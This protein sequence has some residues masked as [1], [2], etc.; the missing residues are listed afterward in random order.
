M[1]EKEIGWGLIYYS[2]Y[3]Q[4]PKILPEKMIKFG[5]KLFTAEIISLNHTL[6]FSK[7]SNFNSG[8]IKNIA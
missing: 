4:L 5:K 1:K 7:K 3:L 2:N 6:D 8:I